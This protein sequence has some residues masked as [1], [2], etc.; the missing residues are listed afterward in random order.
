MIKLLLKM[1]R[2]NSE[3]TET[4][5]ALTEAMKGKDVIILKGKY[6]H[7]KAQIQN[8]NGLAWQDE[9]T[10][11]IKIYRMKGPGFIDDHYHEY[12][13]LKDVVLK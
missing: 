9:H 8:Y 3:R 6:A 4:E 2:L 5:K 11:H 1:E 12:V 13:K 10:I 7:R